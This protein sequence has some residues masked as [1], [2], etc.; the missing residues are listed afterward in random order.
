M[1]ISDTSLIK[2]MQ[3]HGRIIIK[4]NKMTCIF[5]TCISSMLLQSDLNKWR[6]TKLARFVKL[7]INTESTGILQR[8][9][10]YD[11]Q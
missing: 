3:K 7:Y 4:I 10:K 1:C 2:Y 5:E 11:Y 8:S 6:L 9:N